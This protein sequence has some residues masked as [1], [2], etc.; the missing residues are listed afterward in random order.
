MWGSTIKVPAFCWGR[1][2]STWPD[3]PSKGPSFQ[4]SHQRLLWILPHMGITELMSRI[5]NLLFQD[6]PSRS[7]F[8][9]CFVKNGDSVGKTYN[10]TC[11]LWQKFIEDLLYLMP[12]CLSNIWYYKN[13]HSKLHSYMM[14]N[15][16]FVVKISSILGLVLEEWYN[17]IVFLCHVQKVCL[18]NNFKLL[19]II[20][21]GLT[22]RLLHLAT[23][24]S[25]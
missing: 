23:Q 14:N 20:R 21:Q 8:V 18:L 7:L 9:I 6:S 10:F 5:Y 4:L 24:L 25:P 2:D 12:R 15:Y 19:V 11:I 17:R 3:R 22:L 1:Y 13:G 16:V